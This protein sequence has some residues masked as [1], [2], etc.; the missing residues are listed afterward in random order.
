[1]GKLDLTRR[2]LLKAGGL[3]G[4]GAIG[5][6]L[7]GT[8]WSKALAASGSVTLADIGVGDPAGDWS[9]YTD[10]SG[11]DVNL[12]AVGNAPATI[13]NVLLGGGGTSTY[14][15]LHIVGGVQ[16]PLAQLG[17]VLPVDPSRMPNW[18]ANEYISQ[19]F[20]DGRARL[21]AYRP[22]GAGLRHSRPSC[23]ANRS[24]TCRTRPA[25]SALSTPS[26]R[27]STRNTRATWRSR[28]TTPPP[29]TRRRS[30]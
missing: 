23:R 19:Y 16:E 26:A 28:T 6:S 18:G 4:L 3:G 10:K 7:A 30:T 25:A 9:R 13:I 8:P 20:V 12:V 11:W 29:A 21:A 15:A 14:D 1:M 24:A 5:L 27:S 2:S 22:R 17:L